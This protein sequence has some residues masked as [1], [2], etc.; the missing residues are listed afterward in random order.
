MRPNNLLG[1]RQ[2]LIQTHPRR[3]QDHRILRRPQWSDRPGGVLL[4][5]GADVALDLSRID[6]DPSVAQFQPAAVRPRLG[7]GDHEQ[8]QVGVRVRALMPVGFAGAFR[9]SELV[10]LNS[11][12]LE[13]NEN[14]LV[15]HLRR[16]KTDPEGQGRKVGIPYGST[17]ATC[18]VRALKT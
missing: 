13:F 12:D 15:V 17:P 10:G 14:G 8:L 6:V 4:I 18:P 9:W 3:I 5:S 16:S 2:N 11:E 7:A 1:R